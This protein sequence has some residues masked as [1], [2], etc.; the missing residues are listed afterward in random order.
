MSPAIASR[1]IYVI[2][3]A[4]R[5]VLRDGA[6]EAAGAF[7]K[8]LEEPPARGN[9]IL[10]TSEPGA[11]IPTIRSR[12]V[13]V[14]VPALGATDTDAVL[15]EPAMRQAI[16]AAS[17]PSSAAE[18]RRLAGG[19][20]GLL[21]G[22]AEWADALAR[23]RRVLDAALKRDRRA[24]MRTALM[25]GSYRSRGAYSTALDALTTLLHERVRAA[26]ERG[27]GGDARGATAAA[28]ALD[29]V[30]RAKE[31]ATGNVNPQLI[32]SELLRQLEGLLA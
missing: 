1:K 20:P 30:E 29:V 23:A 31:R 12:L 14:R 10:T 2:G 3:E 8:L 25:Q 6:E 28:R 13:A 24:Q 9:I 16:A 7:L 21:L 18:Q 26:A 32:T 19:A 22:G 27:G 11:L 17:G 5:M 4:E 15:A